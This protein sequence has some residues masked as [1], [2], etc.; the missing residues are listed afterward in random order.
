MVAKARVDPGSGG[1]TETSNLMSAP[2][3]KAGDPDTPVELA[4][5]T[6]GVAINA[7]LLSR[8]RDYGRSNQLFQEALDN[9]R[10]KKFGP[11]YEATVRAWYADSLAEQGRT[12]KALEEY[13]RSRSLFEGFG[14]SLITRI[15]DQDIDHLASAKAQGNEDS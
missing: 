9:F 8:K 5:G 4:T 15:L 11:L 10:G 3:V 7:S 2:S 12:E 6:L 1:E 14:N 13:R